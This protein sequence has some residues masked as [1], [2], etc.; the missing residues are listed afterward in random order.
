MKALLIKLNNLPIFDPSLWPRRELLA[1]LTGITICIVFIIH[2]VLRFNKYTGNLPPFLRNSSGMHLS[3]SDWH[4]IMWFSVWIIETG[5]FTG[6]ILAF[7]SRNEAKSIA[8]GFMEVIF[9]VIVAAVPI[10][11]TLTPM[12]FRSVWPPLLRSMNNYTGWAAP[13]FWNW[14]PVF[15]FFLAI[16]ICG[17]MIN[18]TGLLALRKAFTIMSEARALIR[19]GIFSLVRHPLYA[20]HFMVFFGYLMFHLHWYTCALYAMF[21][22]GQYVRARIEERKL[23][24][25]FPEYA[26]Y[27][28][29][30]G[31]FF[32]RLFEKNT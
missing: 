2:R 24:G 7:V 12:N 6:Y 32:P 16:I 9:P 14:E 17:G 31:M 1:R 11:I 18:L 3:A 26:G 13:V 19:Q 4:W 29:T 22:A 21:M 28:R 8:K 20:G 5:I 10:V 15:F 23:M 27:M 25:T 30:T